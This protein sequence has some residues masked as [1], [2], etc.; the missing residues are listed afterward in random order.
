MEIQVAWMLGGLTSILVSKQ[1]YKSQK[2]TQRQK[3]YF[4]LQSKNVRDFFLSDNLCY[5][6]YLRNSLVNIYDLYLRLCNSNTNRTISLKN[7][8]TNFAN[9]L[10]NN[11]DPE[12]IERYQ[13]TRVINLNVNLNI[14]ININLLGGTWPCFI[15]WLRNIV[16][17]NISDLPQIFVTFTICPIP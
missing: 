12:F 4:L 10:V 9:I 3:R 7:Y 5:F 8:V 15:S 16:L 2:Y 14:K 17:P 1:K 13:K 11:I 6:Y